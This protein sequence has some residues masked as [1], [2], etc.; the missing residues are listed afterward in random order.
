MAKTRE[1]GGIKLTE[2]EKHVWEIPK[3]GNMNV[4]ARIFASEKLLERIEGDKTIEQAK[5]VA[6]M[7]GIYKAAMTMP[8]AHQGY[9][10]P[11]GGVAALDAK[12]GAISPG[13]VGY[14]I[15]CGVRMLL[16]N[17]TKDEVEPVKVKL[18]EQI[19]KEVPSGLG[20][21]GKIRVDDKTLKEVLKKGSRW[22]VENGYGWPEDLE[23]TESN[24]E[25]KEADPETISKEAMKRGRPQLGSLGA[26]NHFLEIQVVDKI[27][28]KKIA[29]EWG[30]EKEG[31]VTVMIHCGSRGLGHQTCSDFLRRMEHEYADIIKTLPDRELVYAPANSQ[32]AKDYFGA[33]SASANY[34]W[35]NRQMI[36][37]WVRGAFEKVF[38][39]SAKDLGMHLVYDVAHN[40]AKLEEHEIDGKKRKVYVHRKGA[41][42][43]FP[44]GHPE[45]PKI[46]QK[47]GQPVIIP[48]SMGTASYLLVG[49]EKGF[50]ETFGSTAHGAGRVMSRH[51]A[52]R[53]FRGEQ[54]K[55]DLEKK[56]IYVRS[57]SW[58]GIAEEAP[59]V[60]KDI[61]EV[62]KVSHEVGI[63]NLV[64][65]VVPIGVVKG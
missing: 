46:Y 33:M 2:V 9:G 55:A 23:R 8:D 27:F 11:I 51:E 4:P 26:G 40:M 1:F 43:A 59:G 57:A 21:E 54:V 18:I 19:F 37:H 41:T 56:G 65:R 29:K 53:Q 63:G 17:L 3:S 32:T 6:C 64:V 10:F 12:D 42:R 35:V 5:N 44:A 49:T 24:G 15:N 38:G 25:I 20:S 36:M 7:P 14:D 60:Y 62:V 30:I 48:G 16:T 39:K 50:R 52:M 58:K 45:L 13:G 31:Q 22:A 61:D 28:D 47:T 34:A